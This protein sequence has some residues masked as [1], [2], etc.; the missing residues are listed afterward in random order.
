MGTPMP[1]LRQWLQAEASDQDAL[2]EM[3]FAGLVA[4]TPSIQPGPGFVDRALRAAWQTRVSH[5]LVTRPARIAAALLTAI[6][7]FFSMYELRGLELN[8]IVRGTV[9]F[10]H[11]LAWVLTSA[12]ESGRWWWIAE[13][14][15][16][17]VS[18]TIA[19][20]SAAAAVAAVEM[21]ALLA[22]YAFKQVAPED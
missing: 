16:A 20:P 17:A 3:L 10:S 18:D 8:L 7:G 19:A 15:G 5:R 9:L 6:A 14:I 22:I 21:I 11:G 4:E 12:S 13:R 1:D 2:A